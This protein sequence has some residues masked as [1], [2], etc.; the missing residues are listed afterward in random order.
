MAFNDP[1]LQELNQRFAYLTRLNTVISAEEM[2]VDPLF[3][4]DPQRRDVS[5]IHDLSQAVGLYDCERE[6]GVR[7]RNVSSLENLPA[8]AGNEP[9]NSSFTTGVL[10]GIGSIVLLGGLIGLGIAIGRRSGN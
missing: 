7:I 9:A 2:T 8:V 6:D 4:Y 5:N 3:D 10:V 1:L